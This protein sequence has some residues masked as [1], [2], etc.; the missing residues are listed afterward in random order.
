MFLF[1]LLPSITQGMF[2]GEPNQVYCK[3]RR[4]G[5][6]SLLSGSSG[7]ILYTID[8]RYDKQL[9]IKEEKTGVRQVTVTVSLSMHL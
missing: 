1:V 4:I 6:K 7:E 8:G 9:M 5:K 2:G 3:V